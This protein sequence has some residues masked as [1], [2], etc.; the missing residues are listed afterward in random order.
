MTSKTRAL[1]ETARTNV[2]FKEL[3]KVVLGTNEEKFSR[4]GHNYH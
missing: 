1:D 4:S 2:Q 3:E